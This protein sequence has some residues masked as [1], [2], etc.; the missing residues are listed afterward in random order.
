MASSEFCY[1]CMEEKETSLLNCCIGKYICADC[2]KLCASCPFCRHKLP[3]RRPAIIIV[4]QKDY[5][6]TVG[7]LLLSA[8]TYKIIE[9]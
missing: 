9:L 6:P 8:N 2:K 4:N 1:I 3:T 7:R 5:N